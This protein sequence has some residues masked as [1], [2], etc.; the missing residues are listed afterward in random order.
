MQMHCIDACSKQVS[1]LGLSNVIRTSSPLHECI[2][3]AP[4][5]GE[6]DVAQGFA[7]SAQ[8][9]GVLTFATFNQQKLPSILCQQF[10]AAE[11]YGSGETKT[12][13]SLTL[14]CSR[15]A[16]SP[17]KVTNKKVK[18]LLKDLTAEQKR[19][20]RSMKSHEIYIK[21]KHMEQQPLIEKA[22]DLEGKRIEIYDGT[23]NV[24]RKMEVSSVTAKWIEN[25]T[26]VRISYDLQ[27]FDDSWN[28]VGPKVEVALDQ[29]RWTMLSAGPDNTQMQELT[30][31][32]FAKTTAI[33]SKAENK[34]SQLRGVFER[35]KH[36]L[37]KERKTED[38]AAKMVHDT[39]IQKTKASCLAEST[40]LAAKDEKTVEVP[41]LHRAYLS[42]WKL[43]ITL[44]QGVQ[45][46]NLS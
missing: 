15:L 19:E 17:P 5:N 43:Y 25:N 12:G 45:A 14:D 30:D 21:R 29:V 23:A 24:W 9:R 38:A 42:K 7:H 37:E 16:S 39:I 33:I 8:G 20:L 4:S 11:G 1:Q 10:R 36:A 28:P 18:A 41:S 26:V 3:I 34:L 27:P 46:T 31:Q 44:P 40:I 6:T 32:G 2:Y 13:Q 22:R 35:E